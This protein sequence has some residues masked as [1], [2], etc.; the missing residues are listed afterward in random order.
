MVPLGQVFDQLARVVRQISRELRQGDPPRHHRRRDRDRQADRRGAQRSAD[1]HDPQRHRSRHRAVEQRKRGGQARRRHDRAER[2]PEGQPRDDRGRGRRPRHRRAGA[3]RRRP[4]ASARS[5]P[6]EARE[7]D[8]RRDPQPDLLAR[9][10]H[11][12]EAGD[13][14]SGR[15]VGMDIVKTN[16]AQAR[17]RHRRPQRARH[18]H[19]DDDHA[20][21]HAGDHQ[22]ADRARRR[23]ARS[24][25][26]LASVSEALAFDDSGVRVV[27]G[28][29]V[30]TLRGA[31]LPLCR[32]DR[33]FGLAR[34]ARTAAAPALRGRGVARQPPAR[35]R[36][37][38][39]VGQQDIVIKPLGKSLSAVRGFA[40]ATELG[41]QRVGLVLDAA[42]LDRRGAGR[43]RAQPREECGRMADLVRTPAGSARA[44]WSP[45]AGRC[46]S[47]WRSC[48]RGELY[49]VELT[50]IR[51]S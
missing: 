43:G 20:A 21:D 25:M 24:R 44:A 27:D 32:L 19:Q 30:M 18:R 34:A 23:A 36:R 5:T 2:L 50:R 45:S 6:S 35:A 4:S 28:R 17:R 8:A 15:G 38:S 3:A 31:T 47:F 16:I 29:E 42:A 11:T 37:R 46:A 12:R 13:D 48:W 10:L 9:A 22:R 14:V 49:G 39:P 26:P 41:D 33:L 51:R 1:A 40:G 7:L